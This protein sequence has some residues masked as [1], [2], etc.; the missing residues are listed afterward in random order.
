MIVS[1]LPRATSPSARS[2]IRPRTR[3]FAALEADGAGAPPPG[4]SNPDCV[5][6]AVTPGSPK[7]PSHAL[8]SDGVNLNRL[9]NRFDHFALTGLPSNVTVSSAVCEAFC[10]PLLSGA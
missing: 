10:T 1:P 8:A 7:D 5:G 6:I 3:P 4:N 9:P 2:A